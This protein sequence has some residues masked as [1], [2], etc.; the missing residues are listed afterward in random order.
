MEQKED[1]QK[2]TSVHKLSINFQKKSKQFNGKKESLFLKS[3]FNKHVK[4]GKK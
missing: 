4:Y 3:I 2:S 1:R